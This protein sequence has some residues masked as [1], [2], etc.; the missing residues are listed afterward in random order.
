MRG[1]GAAGA[2]AV[3][4]RARIRASAPDLQRRDTMGAGDAFTGA[5]AASFHSSATRIHALA[6]AVAAG[7]LA[8]ATVGARFALPAADAIKRLASTVE[9]GL[10][11]HPL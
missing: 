8:F 1:G 9:S 2:L 11:S 3:V 10:V 4:G 7:T 5:L 6:L